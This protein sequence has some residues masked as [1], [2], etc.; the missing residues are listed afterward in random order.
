MSAPSFTLPATLD[1]D[2]ATL[3][4]GELASAVQAAQRSTPGHFVVNAGPLQ[5]FDSSALAVLLHCRRASVAAGQSFSV[6]DAPELLI[7]LATLYG[8]RELIPAATG[9]ASASTG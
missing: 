9:S 1:Q 2:G 5:T 7:R 6:Q 8:V 3:L 4:M